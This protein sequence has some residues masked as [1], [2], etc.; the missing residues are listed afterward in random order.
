MRQ[1][2]RLIG[3]VLA[4][5]YRA[6]PLRLSRV[7]RCVSVWV[8]VHAIMVSVLVGIALCFLPDVSTVTFSAT[9]SCVVSH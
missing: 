3:W 2:Q 4:I 8:D 1:V 7:L 9:F 6:S 5:D